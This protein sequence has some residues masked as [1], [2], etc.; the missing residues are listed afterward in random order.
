MTVR[1]GTRPALAPRDP[2]WAA[3]W[4]SPTTARGLPPEAAAR[5][6]ER[7]YRA[8]EARSRD[9]GGTGLGL[10]IVEALV[11]AHGGTVELDTAEGAGATFRVLLP[12]GLTAPATCQ[13]LRATGDA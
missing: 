3:C 11:S 13:T 9:D 8:D 12:L 10:A 1:L 5:V 7:F 2:A 6:F 4:R